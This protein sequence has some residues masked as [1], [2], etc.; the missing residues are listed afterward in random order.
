MWGA[1]FYGPNKVIDDRFNG[2]T[3]TEFPTTAAGTFGAAALSNP[4]EPI[5]ILGAFG[6][7][8]AE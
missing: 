1:Q 3:E 5:S 2:E 8:K 4:K 6:S 7:W